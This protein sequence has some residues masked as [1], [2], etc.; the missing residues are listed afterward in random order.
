METTIMG[1]GF[2]TI[3]LGTRG[4]HTE[5]AHGIEVLFPRYPFIGGNIGIN[6]GYIEVIWDNGR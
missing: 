5:E 2:I 1:L 3:T 6:W 4:S